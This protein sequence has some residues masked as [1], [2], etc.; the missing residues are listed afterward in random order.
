[1]HATGLFEAN[2]LVLS[3]RLGLLCYRD[4]TIDDARGIYF[5][6]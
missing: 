4:T 5:L 1:M 6:V 3:V 2:H